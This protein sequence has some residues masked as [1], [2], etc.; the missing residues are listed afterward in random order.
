MRKRSSP[1]LLVGL[2]TLAVALGGLVTMEAIHRGQA[3][4]ALRDRLRL[5]VEVLAPYAPSLLAESSEAAD[6]EIRRWAAASGLRVTLIAADGHV[7]ADSW[8][9]PS[10]LPRLE[11]HLQRPEIVSART[12]DVGLSHRRSATT[13]HPTTYV[14]RA[15]GSPEHPKG[16]L[17]LAQEDEPQGWPWGQILVAVLV[18]MVAGALSAR[19]ARRHHEAVARHLAP[20]TE[21]PPDAELEAIAEEADRRFRAAREGLT[22]EVEATR[23]A[24]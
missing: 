21:L 8:T 9:L 13:D 6:A 12:G 10:L 17:R 20:W 16:F 1:G 15:V 24:L 22:R 18:A 11:N 3:R 7:H 19:W 4:T 2:G 23:A 14:A 5:A